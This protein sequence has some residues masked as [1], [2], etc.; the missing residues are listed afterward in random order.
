MS[1]TRSL[2]G[3]FVSDVAQQLAGYGF[4]RDAK[5][6]RV[7]RRNSPAGDV[8]IVELQPSDHSSAEE[9][10]FYIN[11]GLVLGPKWESDRQRIKRAPGRLPDTSNASWFRRVN[12]DGEDQWSISDEQAF[13]ETSERARTRLDEVLPDLVRMLDRDWVFAEAPALFRGG[14]WRVR[15][16]LLAD[17]GPSAELERLLDEEGS[18]RNVPEQLA[19]IR[20]YAR[21]RVAERSE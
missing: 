15:A 19:R 4:D 3:R 21:T 2:F 7:F 16:W 12:H 6:R 1:T 14:A 17:R 5:N 8:V 11:L 10:V 9:T 18:R 13:G 20:E